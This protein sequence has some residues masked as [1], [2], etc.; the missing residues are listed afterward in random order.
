MFES[1][2]LCLSDVCVVP[3]CLSDVSVVTVCLCLPSVESP[4]CVRVGQMFES[5]GW[6]LEEPEMD[7]TTRYDVLA[8]TVVRPPA[9]LPVPPPEGTAQQER[10]GTH[11]GS[12]KVS[13][14]G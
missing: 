9:G 5:T 14:L 13:D 11:M 7:E 10:Q 1:T 12:A 3:V 4:L 8:P 6:S 2:R